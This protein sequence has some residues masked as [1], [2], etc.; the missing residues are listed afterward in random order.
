MPLWKSTQ[1]SFAAGQL[2]ALVMGRQDMDKYF[3]GATRLENF[4]VRRQG[5]ISKRRGTDLSAS[6]DN[7]LGLDA[8]GSPI[9][10][11]KVR[12]VGVNNDDDGR[13]V[14]LSG[15]ACFVASRLGILDCNR[16]WRRRLD[17]YEA[18]DTLGNPKVFGGEDRRYNGDTPVDCI[19]ITSPGVYRVTRHATLQ[20]A[21]DAVSDGGIV[22]LHADI[23]I[24]TY[25]EVKLPNRKFTLDLYGYTVRATSTY[26]SSIYTDGTQT[27]SFGLTVTSTRRGAKFVCIARGGNPIGIKIDSVN[28]VESNSAHRGTLVIDGEIDWQHLGSNGIIIR[29]SDC[30]VTVNSGRF[31]SPTEGGNTFLHLNGC[32][33]EINGGEFLANREKTNRE[34]CILHSSTFL[35]AT[36][37]TD[38]TLVVRGGRFVCMSSGTRSPDPYGSF[39]I[40]NYNVGK[41]PVEIRGGRFSALSPEHYFYDL[42]KNSSWPGVKLFRGEFGHEHV[43]SFQDGRTYRL[44]E[45][46]QAGSKVNDAMPNESGCY[47]VKLDGEA[48][49]TLGAVYGTPPYRITVPYADDDLADICIRQCGDTLFLAHRK[50]APARIWFDELGLAHFAELEFDNTSVPPPVIDSVSMDGQDPK[51]TQYPEQFCVTFDADGNAVFGTDKYPSWLTSAQKDTLKAFIMKWR[52]RGVVTNAGFVENKSDGSDSSYT[53]SCSF[54]MTVEHVDRSSGRKTSFVAV[55]SFTGSRTYE[56]ETQY[57]DGVATGSTRNAITTHGS[58]ANDASA[59]SVLVPRTVRYV[60]TQV[61]DGHESRPSQPVEVKYDMPWA[62]NAVVNLSF[63]RGAARLEPEYYNVYKDNGSGYGLVGTT[64]SELLSGSVEGMLDTYPLYAPEILG[65]SVVNAADLE[66]RRGWSPGSLLR[67]LASTGRKTFSSSPSQDISVITT[68]KNRANGIQFTFTNAQYTKMRVML[69]AR[70]YDP[71]ADMSYLVISTPRVTAALKLEMEDG[72]FDTTTA[73][74]TAT[75]PQRIQ[76]D[77]FFGFRAEGIYEDWLDLPR[78]DLTAPNG[79]TVAAFAVGQGAQREYF[80]NHLR[81]LV[82]DFTDK[83][84]DVRYR[85]IAGCTLTFDSSVYADLMTPQQGVIHQVSFFNS[86]SAG[87]LDGTFQDD[88]INPD[89]TVTPPRDD[90]DP[91]FSGADEYPGCVGVYEQRLVFASS[92]AYPS[93]VWLSRTADLYNF[94]AHESI[95]EDDAL[96]LTLAATEFP[97]INHVVMGR[98]L[99]LFADGG[100]WVVS[101]Y[102]G[103]ALTFKTASCRLQSYI[104]SSRTLEPIQ[105]GDETVF[106]ERGGTTLR[107]INYNYSSDSYKSMD[108][109]VI[110]ASIFKANPIV[111]MAYKQHPDSIIECVLADGTVATLVYMP[112]QEVAAWSVQVL[113]GGWK[114]REVATPKCIVNGTTETMFLVERD[115]AWALWKVR[116]DVDTD[117]AEDRVVLDGL[118]FEDDGF[119]PGGGETAV[120]VGNGRCAVGH[121]VRSDFVCVRPEPEQG[122]TAQFEVKNATESEIR[123]VDASTFAVKPY[124]ASDGWTCFN[125]PALVM[126]DGSVTLVERDAKRVLNGLNGR[127]GRIHLRH[128]EAWPLTILSVSNTFQVEYEN[129]QRGDE[130]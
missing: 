1:H 27:S 43:H 6:L 51:E 29:A 121:A 66:E 88:Y 71:E 77:Y 74:V 35:H 124:R 100:E 19:N 58:A 57:R 87:S 97:D 112:E 36:A 34:T 39:C 115:G 90:A 78:V 111:S 75:T 127:D 3:R 109:S 41:A 129:Q 48:D 37:V 116:D 42:R 102:Q 4:L 33:A 5:C 120:Y 52:S 119:E 96:E 125:L 89:M 99:M 54:S 117:R 26:R 91:H 85:R 73:K 68:E 98:E 83:L 113:G 18:F 20:E 22:R 31:T 32:H 80:N 103:N 56:V 50:Y 55:Q 7:L 101:P 14:I 59:S 122:A 23:R 81:E 63:S 46:V 15:G 65:F 86:G 21:V 9:P 108:L 12:L 72:T 24:E 2:D 104:G 30:D 61:R 95:R 13:Y 60:V 67:K 84:K 110:S 128:A 130:R 107:T 82:F 62:N 28:S 40:L 10:V 45:I 11:G 8:S 79:D 47:G 44:G 25:H 70:I 16:E 69:D 53:Q 49:Y 17:P 76:G 38:Q 126:P 92:R 64:N 114:A 106:A 93:T 123:V 94:T 118:H 105:V